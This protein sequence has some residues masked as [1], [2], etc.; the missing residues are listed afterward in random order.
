MKFMRQACDHTFADIN[1]SHLFVSE[2]IGTVSAD[3]STLRYLMDVVLLGGFHI[4]I[5]GRDKRYRRDTAS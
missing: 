4:V 1:P 5:C 3:A 2:L